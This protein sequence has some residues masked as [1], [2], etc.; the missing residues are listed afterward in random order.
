MTLAEQVAA[1]EAELAALKQKQAE[2]SKPWPQVGDKYWYLTPNGVPLDPVWDGGNFDLS[3]QAIGNIFRTEE[4]S[5]REHE[6]QVVITE[7]RAQ[8]GRRPFVV[9]AN[10]YGFS[11][12]AKT[13]EVGRAEF[14][15]DDNNWQQINFGAAEHRNA[16]IA[17]VGEARILAA[18]QWMGEKP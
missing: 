17:T 3:C 10:N 1:L 12:Y 5:E 9:G 18:M 11:L 7:L 2:E 13:L 14:K 4:E 6:A 16:A 8:P 15:Y